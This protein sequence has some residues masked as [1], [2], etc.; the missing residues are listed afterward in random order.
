MVFK[1]EMYFEIVPVNASGI[2]WICASKRYDC[3]ELFLWHMC[4]LDVRFIFDAT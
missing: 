2:D 4:K 3:F 1:V